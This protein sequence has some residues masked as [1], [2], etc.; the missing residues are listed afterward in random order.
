MERGIW[1]EVAALWFLAAQKGTQPV[2]S[3]DHNTGHSFLGIMNIVTRR[4]NPWTIK[5]AFI[6]FIE[7]FA[8]T[9]KTTPSNFPNLPFIFSPTSP[10][11]PSSPSSVDN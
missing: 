9:K 3:V 1:G 7:S 5:T 10:S 2:K 11:C 8:V 6:P 4:R